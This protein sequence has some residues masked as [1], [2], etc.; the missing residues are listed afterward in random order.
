ME[1]L[2]TFD[3][4]EIRKTLV[5]HF[6]QQE[7]FEDC[8]RRL[9]EAT[10]FKETDG[11]TFDVPITSPLNPGRNSRITIGTM[12]KWVPIDMD[13]K[14]VEE[15][16]AEYGTVVESSRISINPQG[17]NNKACKVETERIRITMKL[18]KDIPT[19]I[20][21]DGLELRVY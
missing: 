12:I 11:N 18:K 7:Q 10:Q 1:S 9:G 15:A 19:T 21:V 6:K 2:E 13:F 8:L 14:L 20:K 5:I 4:N 3:Y 16:L 17:G